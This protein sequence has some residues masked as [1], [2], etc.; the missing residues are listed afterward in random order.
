MLDHL[1]YATP[2]VGRSIDQLESLLGV[3]AGFG[4]QHPGAGTHNALLSFGEGSYLEIIGPDPTQEPPEDRPM[5]FGIDTLVA[6]RLV[7]WAV[8]APNIAARVARAR[9]QGY[10]PGTPAAMSRQ[11]PDGVRL[12]WM[13]TRAP[14]QVGDG[15][16]PFLIDWGETPHPSESAPG[17][18]RL[19]S[20]RGEHP[21][22]DVV[23]AALA[24]IGAELKVEQGPEPALLATIEGRKAAI[25]LR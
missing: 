2:D 11:R 7:T 5:P 16:V 10:D 17:G 24:A 3:R 20:L 1:V 14:V 25:E 21:Q 13:L 23:L 12:G 4:G 19:V 15:L 9:E 18:C 8:K 6:P 22:P